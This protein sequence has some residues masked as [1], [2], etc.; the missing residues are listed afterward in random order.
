MK[1]HLSPTEFQ[2]SPRPPLEMGELNVVSLAQHQRLRGV[3]LS[4]FYKKIGYHPSTFDILQKS[5]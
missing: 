1:L 4:I 5:L 2:K 3:T